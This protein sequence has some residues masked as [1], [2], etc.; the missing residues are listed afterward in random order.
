MEQQ[1][2]VIARF[3]SISKKLVSNENSVLAIILIALIFGMG[4]MTNGRT[5]R[6][7][8]A[9]NVLVQS[10]MVGVAS[11]GQAF[12]ILTAGIDLSVGGIGLLAAQ[13]GASLMSSSLESNL[14]GYVVPAGIGVLVIISVATGLGILNGIPISRIGIPP[15]LMTLAMWQITTGLAFA[16]NGGYPI[17]D[18]PKSLAFLG[19][20]EILS[21]PVPIIILVVVFVIAYFILEHTVYGKSLYAVG[22]NPASAWLSGIPA[23]KTITFAYLISGLLAGISGLIFTGRTLSTNMD[24]MAGLEIDSIIAV[25]IGG[26]SLMGG[27]GSIVGVLLGGIILG[28]INNGLSVMQAGSPVQL[29]VKGALIYAAVTIDFYRRRR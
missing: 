20:G 27:R 2:P 1:P 3:R 23:R 26:V 6:F 10:S 29:I 9:V 13:L 8:N 5:L 7:A 18:L 19:R 14:A 12:V 15:L 11:V 25:S 21:V 4:Y 17:A 28:V 16:V 22:G 24:T